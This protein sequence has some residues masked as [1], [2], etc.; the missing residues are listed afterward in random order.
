[1]STTPAQEL[2]EGRTIQLA[3]GTSV[4]V[5]FSMYTLAVIEEEFGSIHKVQ[6]VFNAFQGNQ[7][8]EG[9]DRPDMKM[10][11]LLAQIIHSALLNDSKPGRELDIVTLMKL[12]PLSRFMQ[13]INLIAEAL[14]EGFQDP[15]TTTQTTPPTTASAD[16]N[17]GNTS[18][19]GA[20][21][22]INPAVTSGV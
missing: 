2:G 20:Q 14:Q 21:S 11:R 9:D 17:G 13:T 3:D 15:Q 12:I 7:G 16:S 10:V 18:T 19:S 6:E 22:S 4:D 8:D 1:M 5:V